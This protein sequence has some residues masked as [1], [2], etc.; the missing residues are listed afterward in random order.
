M[1]GGGL[2]LLHLWNLGCQTSTKVP[3]EFF[4][5]LRQDVNAFAKLQ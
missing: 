3:R 5:S 1:G 2:H 4:S